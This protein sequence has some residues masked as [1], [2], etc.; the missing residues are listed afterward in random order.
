MQDSARAR[1]MQF[2]YPGHRTELSLGDDPNSEELVSDA[3]TLPGMT[4]TYPIEHP[5][6]S[7]CRTHVGQDQFEV[8]VALRCDG[9]APGG[10]LR[11]MLWVKFHR[12]GV[13]RLPRRCFSRFH[14]KF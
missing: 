12:N 10:G 13:R 14:V 11:N 6:S 1:D 2:A 7:A 8:A 5:S 4:G 9:S 3:K